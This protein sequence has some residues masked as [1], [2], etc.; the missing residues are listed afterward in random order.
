LGT[1]LIV[2]AGGEVGCD[3]VGAFC[4]FCWLLSASSFLLASASWAIGG[5]D[6]SSAKFMLATSSKMKM[7]NL[8]IVTLMAS[9]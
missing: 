7:A 8:T 5:F 3:M 6:D 2:N 9:R 1:G 4:L